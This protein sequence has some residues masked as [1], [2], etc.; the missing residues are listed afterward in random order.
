MNKYRNKKTEYK[1][2]LFDSTAEKNRY[3]ELELL[4]RAGE[5][6]GLRLQPKFVL[7]PKFTAKSGKSRR[8]STF[9]ADFA[10]D[11]W[12][13]GKWAAV[14][15][16]VKSSATVKNQGYVLRR[17]LFEFQNPDIEF[18]EVIM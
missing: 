2:I 14:I 3:R 15:E 6:A 12:R 10:Y 5:I 1:G 9:T 4:E 13:D 16:D 7:I 17:N 8:A 11:E 18:K